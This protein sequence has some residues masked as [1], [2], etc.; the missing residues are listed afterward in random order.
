MSAKREADCPVG[1][2]VPHR[3]QQQRLRSHF[4]RK[5]RKTQKHH[6]VCSASHFAARLC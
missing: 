4:P 2:E 3:L 6:G 5:R 1:C